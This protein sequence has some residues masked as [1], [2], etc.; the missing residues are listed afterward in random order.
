M[1]GQALHNPNFTR[2]GPERHFLAII[3]YDDRTGMFTTQDPGT[4][5]GRNYRYSYETLYAAMRDY[6]TGDH[7]AIATNVRAF[8]SISK[9]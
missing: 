5:N 8:I 2:G 9:V 1:N 4:R 7:Q 6:P 3:G